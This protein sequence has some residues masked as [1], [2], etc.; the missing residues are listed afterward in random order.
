MTT[1]AHWNV[2]PLDLS[3]RGNLLINIRTVNLRAGGKKSSRSSF[4]SSSSSFCSS[5]SL[6]RYAKFGSSSAS[7]C[8]KLH[9]GGVRSF[10][11]EQQQQQQQQKHWSSEEEVV[12]AVAMAGCAAA[13]AHAAPLKLE[14]VVLTKE[15]LS[16][17][18]AEMDKFIEPIQQHPDKREGA[19]PYY[20]LHKE[21]EHVYGTVL[22]FHG[23]AAS[24]GQMARLAQYLFENGFNVYQPALCGHYYNNPAKYWPKVDL[25]PKMKEAVQ[26]K[27]KADPELSAII[28]SFKTIT[29]LTTEMVNIV[30]ERLAVG[31]PELFQAISD[32][33]YTETFYKWFESQDLD[34][35][36]EAEARL[37]EVHALPGPIFTVGLSM[38]GAVS[39]ALAAA[40]P[41]KIAKTAVFSPLLKVE[42]QQNRVFCILAGPLGA[43]ESGWYPDMPFSLGCFVAVDAFGHFV[44]SNNNHVNVLAKIP[45]FVVLTEIDDSADVTAAEKF[46]TGLRSCAG[47]GGPP[48]LSSIYPTSENVPHPMVDPTEVSQGTTNRYWTTLYQETFRFLTQGTVHTENLHKLSQDPGLPQV[49]P[50]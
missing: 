25:K 14:K 10:G 27:L 39:L 24:T 2:R 42:N 12:M 33:D 49:H 17:A 18:R 5:H 38:G 21:G 50:Q 41:D 48:H 47:I 15:H 34:Y 29:D 3:V 37:K 16:L 45:T 32:E 35:L 30:E 46:I 1:F 23:F 6:Q 40:H 28:N 31:D 36:R 4:S 26:Q 44:R 20:L 22:M 43:Q 8:S 7:R 9:R 11:Q 13:A 19:L